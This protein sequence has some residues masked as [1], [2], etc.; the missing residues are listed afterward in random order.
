MATTFPILRLLVPSTMLLA[1]R[2]RERSLM[3]LTIPKKELDWN[4]VEGR[5]PQPGKLEKVLRIR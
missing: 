4:Y 5:T 1:P 2:R 3:L